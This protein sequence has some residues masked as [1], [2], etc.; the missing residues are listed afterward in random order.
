MAAHGGL[1]TEQELAEYR[2]RIWEP[3]LLATYRGRRL[4][5]APAAY[6]RPAARAPAPLLLVDRIGARHSVR[7]T[8]RL[9]A[10]V[11]GSTG[12]A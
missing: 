10:G 7:P 6:G 2:P 3:G 1:V 8:R 4:V 11:S 5:Q 12:G 9:A